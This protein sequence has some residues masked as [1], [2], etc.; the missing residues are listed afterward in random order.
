M[1]P[2]EFFQTS[3]R[4]GLDERFDAG[5]FRR[6]TLR[7][8]AEDSGDRAFGARPAL[9]FAEQLFG[10]VDGE[11]GVDRTAYGRCQKLPPVAAEPIGGNVESNAAQNKRAEAWPQPGFV[12]SYDADALARNG[13]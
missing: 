12:D 6:R 4:Q 7:K 3:V 9:R 5:E 10:I 2:T 8:G 13:Y 11:I 1:L